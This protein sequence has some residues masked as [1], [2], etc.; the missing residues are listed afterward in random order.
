MLVVLVVFF[1][2]T[3]FNP[4]KKIWA[5]FYLVRKKEWLGILF[6]MKIVHRVH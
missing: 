5:F 2:S 3:W 4:G 1:Y 6:I